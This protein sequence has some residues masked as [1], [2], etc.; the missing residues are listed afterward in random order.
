MP[1]FDK[2]CETAR[3]KLTPYERELD[4]VLL[5][6]DRLTLLAFRKV[7]RYFDERLGAKLLSRVLPVTR[8]VNAPPCCA[9]GQVA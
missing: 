1:A 7:C 4:H 6:G 9:M 3:E 8:A 5:G 2:A